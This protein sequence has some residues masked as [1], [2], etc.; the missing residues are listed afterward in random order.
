MKG[1]DANDIA[2]DE[3]MPVL[4]D[5]ID[6]AENWHTPRLVEVPLGDPQDGL[7]FNTEVDRL[8]ALD[9]PRYERERKQAAK[10]LQ[11]RAPVLDSLV[12]AA[13]QSSDDGKQGRVLS[14]PESKPWP[15]QINGSDLLDVLASA[16]RRH[17]VMSDHSADAAA[18]WVVHTHMLQCLGISP[19]LAVVSPEKGCGKTTLLDVLARL[20]ARPLST[21]NASSAAIFRVV[22]IYQPTLLIDEADTFL[23]EN[24]ELR[25]ILNSGHRRGGSVI[26]VVGEE[27]EPRSFSTYSACAIALIGQLPSTLADRSVLIE[28]RRRRPDEVIETFRF[29]RTDQLDE[30]AC[31]IS[32]WAA[33]TSDAIRG[34]D[35]A[36]PD[37]V[38]NRA[39]DNWRPLLAIAEA[40]GSIWPA[41]A[42][43][44]ARRDRSSVARAGEQS[45]RVQALLDIRMIF[46]E[47]QADRL[48][49]KEI[50]ETLVAM[51]GR[52]WAEWGKAGK[53]ITQ[54]ALARLLSPLRITPES[55]RIGDSTPK[56]YLLARFDDAFSRYL[57]AAPE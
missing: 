28:L 32:R 51:E 5:L 56:G 31:K 47:R 57:P 23:P 44:A 14:F 7:E 2:R 27:L 35:P 48:T 13:R 12:M 17:V 8:A 11:I 26:R 42:Q 30:L 25:G 41:R 24:D 22:E 34:A 53:P 18:L 20:V 52:P 46:A 36:M 49:S 16:I 38:F 19:R 21:A 29:D 4:R 55:V 3:G 45:A 6:A 1:A 54:N 37:G 33:D 40:A 43:D 39:A 50:V 15:K 9:V 10:F